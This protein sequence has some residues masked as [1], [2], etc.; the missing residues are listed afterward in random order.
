MSSAKAA[1]ERETRISAPVDY[2]ASE[3]QAPAVDPVD[4]LVPPRDYVHTPR[5]QK[6]LDSP[7][8]LPFKYFKRFCNSEIVKSLMS[9]Y[10]HLPAPFRVAI[11]ILQGGI[12]LSAI[13]TLCF[14]GFFK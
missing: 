4:L 10:P 2:L 3:Q 5:M 7:W 8:S 6:W 12:I 1:L 9:M 14:S 13:W 11:I